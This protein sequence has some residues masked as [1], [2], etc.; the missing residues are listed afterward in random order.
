MGRPGENGFANFL[1]L[2]CDISTC[3]KLM[4]I[5]LPCLTNT[6]YLVLLFYMI[7]AF[8]SVHVLIQHIVT[9]NHFLQVLEVVVE[10][11]DGE[12][13]AV[14]VEEGGVVDE[15]VAVEDEEVRVKLFKIS[16]IVFLSWKIY[17]HRNAMTLPVRRD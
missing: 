12:E 10:E 14:V 1:T 16:H 4:F 2:F 5:S 6:K 9:H 13:E 8:A 11:V 3:I 17:A 7:Q 15:A